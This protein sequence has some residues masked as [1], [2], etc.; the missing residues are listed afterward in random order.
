MSRAG[1][2]I[3]V[4]LVGAGI[5]VMGNSLLTTLLPLRA[6]LEGF[7][8]SA[9]GIMGGVHFA[10]FILGCMLGPA[11]VQAVGHV[12]VYAGFAALA[13]ALALVFPMQ[14]DLILWCG[15]RFFGG[16]A[17]AC[18]YM[19]I[20]SW[21]N[22]QASN[23]TRGMVLS[24]YIIVGNLAMIAGQQAVTVLDPQ[25]YGLFSMVA[26]MLAVSLMPLALAPAKEPTP[27]PSAKLRLGRLV[28]LS[29]TGVVGCLLAGAMEGAFWT[30]S[31]VFGQS[32]G[33]SVQGIA[34]LLSVFIAGG[35]LSQWPLGWW[36][37][38]V[39]RRIVIVLCAAMTC[40][41]SL[42]LGLVELPDHHW[43]LAVAL[44]HGG[45]MMPLY[46]LLLAHA[47]DFAPQEELVEVSGGLRLTFG[48]GAAVGPTIIGPLMRVQ[49][50]GGLFLGIAVLVAGI[51]LFALLRLAGNRIA[52]AET[53]TSFAVVPKTSQSV[54]ELECDDEEDFVTG[55]LEGLGK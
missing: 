25:N 51:A 11:A 48:V 7:S 9:I 5:V 35:T 27:I 40:V 43:V 1:R 44:V 45:F 26:M 28:R 21:L 38:R 46:P 55:D 8:E 33:L 6:D 17:V 18:C 36:S 2:S 49:G 39:D 50:P 22:D 23:K 34:L 30:L 14:V 24:I 52:G 47:N 12:R 4:V 16:V 31:P 20:E 37:D 41:T 15:L 53:R 32:T 29:P 42:I 3:L 54:Y 10:G 19:V 13:A